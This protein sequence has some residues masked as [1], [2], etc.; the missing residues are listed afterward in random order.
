MLAKQPLLF[1]HKAKQRGCFVIHI[2]WMHSLLLGRL[3]ILLNKAQCICVTFRAF[4]NARKHFFLK[5]RQ[6]FAKRAAHNIHGIHMLR[7]V[8][9]ILPFTSIS[10]VSSSFS[11]PSTSA[12]RG[13]PSL[14]CQPNQRRSDP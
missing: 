5:D 14:D 4:T 2:G 10:G 8:F 6:L 3:Q 12:S 13:A 9:L 1:G 7:T 11:S